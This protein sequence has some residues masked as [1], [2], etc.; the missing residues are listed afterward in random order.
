M[1]HTQILTVWSDSLQGVNSTQRQKW[2]FN[3]VTCWYKKTQKWRMVFV[4]LTSAKSAPRRGNFAGIFCKELG[5]QLSQRRWRY[6][7]YGK[8]FFN[9]NSSD[10]LAVPHLP[11][12]LTHLIKLEKFKMVIWSVSDYWGDDLQLVC[13]STAK[14][15]CE[16]DGY[17][18]GRLS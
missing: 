4:T 15:C 2:F 7:K 14:T 6:R 5:L 9:S 8:L 11:R 16:F 17:I 1:C 3:S 10:I 18:E 12:N 13:N